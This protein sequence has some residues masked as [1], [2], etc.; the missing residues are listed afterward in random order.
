V[1]VF[2]HGVGRVYESP[3]PL[4]VYLIGAALT[5][6]ASFAIRILA[7]GAKPL[8]PEGRVLPA[9]PARWIILF[10]R[11][12][13]LVFFV[14][15]IVS[16]V[17]VGAQGANFTTFSFWVGL[18][19]GM[20]ALCALVAGSWEAADPWATTERF[21]RVE[22]AEI[23]PRVPPWW[24]GPLL[25]FALFWFELVSTVGYDSFWVV[26]A[27]VG[28]S[29]YAFTLRASF[30]GNWTTADPLAILFG[31]AS[32]SAPLVLRPEG[33]FVRS[34]LKDLEDDEGPMPLGLYVSVFVLLASTTFDN[35]SETV[36]WHDFLSTIGADALPHLLVGT[37][38]LALF[39]LPFLGTYLATMWLAQRQLRY[40]GGVGS[41][42]RVFGWSLVPIGIAYVLAH[43]APLLITGLPQLVRFMSDPFEQGWNL[44]GTAYL[45]QGFVASPRL[46]WFIE[47]ALI[48]SGHILAVLAGHRTAVRLA[49]SESA[50]ARSQYAL[51]A[52]MSLYTIVTLWLLAQPL[53]A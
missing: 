17:V 4:S 25:L 23:K 10:L 29:L 41:L 2:A 21:Y 45:W 35:L 38:A 28:Y 1:I 8:R 39:A 30:G 15:T 44:L 14:L 34:P 22:D 48:V 46:V 16:G 24:L 37:L 11:G 32:R 26:A 20:T 40:P 3:I 7:P 27:L 47:I 5:V 13:A 52:L 9:S 43:N 12:L 53:V 49:P 36:G 31:F 50:A 18:I 51:T 19:V 42:G 6:L 33:V